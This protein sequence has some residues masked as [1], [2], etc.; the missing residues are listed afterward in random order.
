[1][2]GFSAVVPRNPFIILAFLTRFLVYF[3]GTGRCAPGAAG[4]KR[5]G[6][7][8]SGDPPV[9]P[10][11]VFQTSE[12]HRV[13]EANG[14]SDRNTAVKRALDFDERGR[15]IAGIRGHVENMEEY[16][17]RLIGEFEQEYKEVSRSQSLYEAC[18][19]SASRRLL[20]QKPVVQSHSR[21]RSGH[22][23]FVTEN[24]GGADSH[25]FRPAR[26]C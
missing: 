11:I 25:R 5:K 1:M 14:R 18:M 2:V 8:A 16:L 22:S 9:S 10:H 3:A 13:S 7:L 12:L 15:S 24:G 20:R 21:R 4:I 19:K 17:S 26:T 6:L 23:G